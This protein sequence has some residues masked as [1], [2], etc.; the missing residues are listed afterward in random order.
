MLDVQVSGCIK[1]PVPD[2]LNSGEGPPGP[3]ADVVR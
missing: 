1:V 2:V 3:R